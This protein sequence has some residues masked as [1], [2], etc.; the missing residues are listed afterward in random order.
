MD[1][2]ER[3]R[4]EQRKEDERIARR[5]TIAGVALVVVLLALLAIHRMSK[6]CGVD[7]FGWENYRSCTLPEIWS[8][9]LSDAGASWMFWAAL[10]IAVS[11]LAA[12]LQD[13]ND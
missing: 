6:D 12:T 4:H 3:R 7:L 8:W 5:H 13:E 1:L 2:Y 10:I 11:A 9:L